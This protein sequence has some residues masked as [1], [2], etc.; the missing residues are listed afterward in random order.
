LSCQWIAIRPVCGIWPS[1]ELI[2]D[3]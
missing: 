1:I 3:V 2:S